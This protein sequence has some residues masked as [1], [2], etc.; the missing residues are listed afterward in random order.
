MVNPKTKGS[1]SQHLP[2]IRTP[3]LGNVTGVT[4]AEKGVQGGGRGRVDAREV[5]AFLSE[6]LQQPP[7]P[8]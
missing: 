8:T 7:L 5:N 3:I 6:V 2:Q 4:E 1:I